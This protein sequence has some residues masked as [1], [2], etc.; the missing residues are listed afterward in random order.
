MDATHLAER[1]LEAVRIAHDLD[2]VLDAFLGEALVRAAK[3]RSEP[4]APTGEERHQATLELDDRAPV[5]HSR[6]DDGRLPPQGGEPRR[7][8]A[9]ADQLERAAAWPEDLPPDRRGRV[10]LFCT[11]E[12]FAHRPDPVPEEA[13]DARTEQAALVEGRQGQQLFPALGHGHE[14]APAPE[15]PPPGQA[16]ERPGGDRRAGGVGELVPLRP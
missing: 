7:A 16:P 4:F 12:Q 1:L 8:V 14:Q 9:V 15:R 2:A 13:H 3:R 6:A 11:D 5:V 10:L